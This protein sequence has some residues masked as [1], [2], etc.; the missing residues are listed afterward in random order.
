M[1]EK[2]VV[3]GEYGPVPMEENSR[4]YINKEPVTIK[5]TAYYA[6]RLMAGEL[7]ELSGD[8]ADAA[9]QKLA[10]EAAAQAAAEKAHAESVARASRR[11]HHES[12]EGGK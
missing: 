11:G 3:A 12:G 2:T 1:E 10:A 6:R 9:T 4:R 8:Q 5:V 7:I